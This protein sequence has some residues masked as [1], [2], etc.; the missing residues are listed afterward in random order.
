MLEPLVE[1]SESIQFL[2]FSNLF[3]LIVENSFSNVSLEMVMSTPYNSIRNFLTKSLV[4]GVE[5][6]F[7]K[8]L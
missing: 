6:H 1:V 5:F 2:I 7:L 8:L 4:N 3:N